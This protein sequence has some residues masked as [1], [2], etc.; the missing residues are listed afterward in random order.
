VN[1]SKATYEGRY[2]IPGLLMGYAIMPF[3][4]VRLSEFLKKY[5]QKV[6]YTVLV[7]II[8]IITVYFGRMTYFSFGYIRQFG[9]PDTRIIATDWLVSNTDRNDRILLESTCNFPKVP[10]EEQAFYMENWNAYPL[11][12]SVNVDYI[13]VNKDIYH[14]L[15][16][17]HVD[18]SFQVFYETLIRSQEWELVYYE[19]PLTGKTTGP[20]IEVYKYIYKD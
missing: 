1:T 17:K 4:V 18:S 10:Y 11:L 19:K 20:R 5:G 12:D 7:A 14:Y 8:L 3:A 15:N 6:R 13:I 9:L 16:S 2:F